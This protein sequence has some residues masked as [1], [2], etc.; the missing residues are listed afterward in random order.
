MPLRQKFESG[1]R[2]QKKTSFQEVKV[3]YFGYVIVLLWL[4]VN[5][6]IFNW[7]SFTFINY[8]QD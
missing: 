8:P 3:G 2:P 4:Y 5:L 1:L 7:G 6:L